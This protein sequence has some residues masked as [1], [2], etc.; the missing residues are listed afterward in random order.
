MFKFLKWFVY[1][2]L[3]L[4]LLLV[5]SLE[6]FYHYKIYQLKPHLS[7]IQQQYSLSAK[8]ILWVETSE[9]GDFELEKLTV[10]EYAINYASTVTSDRSLR[11][12]FIPIK[13]LRLAMMASRR[14]SVDE[15]VSERSK[16]LHSNYRINQ[17]IKT[18]WLTRNTTIDEL[19]E[20]VHD[21]AYF[22]TRELGLHSASKQYFGKPSAD[23][24]RHELISLISRLK[25]F[26]YYDPLR[27]PKRFKKRAEAITERLRENW[28]E[29]YGEYYFV[30]P[31]FLELSMKANN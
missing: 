7:P 15:E 3:T 9:I 25:G 31:V 24:T 20:Y 6:L 23:L 2:V 4:M 5:L 21:N 14:V 16:N 22:G 8:E 18:V 19:L 26:S 12:Q 10:T 13:G 11:N 1:S 17:I 27:F 30:T 29:K 28:P